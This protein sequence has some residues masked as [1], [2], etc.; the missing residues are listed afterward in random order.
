MTISSSRLLHLLKPGS[1]YLEIGIA[2]GNTFQ[3]VSSVHENSYGCDPNLMSDLTVNANLWKLT[4]NEFFLQV[5]EPKFDV[6]FID[7][8][9]TAEQAMTDFVNC[10]NRANI[11]G[12]I[13]IDDVFPDSIASSKRSLSLYRFSRVMNLISTGFKPVG[14][15]GDVFRLIAALPSLQRDLRF[16]TIYSENGGKLQTLVWGPSIGRTVLDAQKCISMLPPRG[17]PSFRLF[18]RQPR[19]VEE[20]PNWFNPET[21]SQVLE[22]IK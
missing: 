6:F 1:H 4:S 16:R 12:L 11:G 8:L 15:Q 10:V 2:S 9:H 14:W 22:L 18:G 13:L 3:D 19:S 17:N 20:I 7:G 5:S 21:F